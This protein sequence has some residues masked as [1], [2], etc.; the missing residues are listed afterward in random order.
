MSSRAA[1]SAAGDSRPPNIKQGSISQ[2]Y[3]TFIP[4]LQLDRSL[5]VEGGC[6]VS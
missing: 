5:E 1:I 3:I 4:S 6:R 2:L